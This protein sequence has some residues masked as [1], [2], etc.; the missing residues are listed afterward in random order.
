MSL[1][2]YYSTYAGGVYSCGSNRPA[3]YNQSQHKTPN[4]CLTESTT[5]FY[6]HNEGA[7]YQLATA[8]QYNKYLRYLS[9]NGG[10]LREKEGRDVIKSL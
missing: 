3:V 5:D 1:W 4:Q 6:H 10:L 8:L 7:I 9:E 2:G